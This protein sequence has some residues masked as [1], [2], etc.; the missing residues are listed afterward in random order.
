MADQNINSIMRMMQKAETGEELK[1]TFIIALEYM[2]A[3]HNRMVEVQ[4]E[5]QR[6]RETVNH[7]T[8]QPQ[9]IGGPS[10]G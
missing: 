6:L 2:E 4:A 3:V 5:V 9:G 7:L 1:T 10:V 8:R